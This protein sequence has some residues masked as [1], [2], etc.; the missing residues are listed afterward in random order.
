MLLIYKWSHVHVLFFDAVLRIVLVF[1][2]VQ[3]YNLRSKNLFFKNCWQ[4]PTKVS[5][6]Y[7]QW[8]PT[9]DMFLKVPITDIL[10]FFRNIFQEQLSWHKHPHLIIHIIFTVFLTIVYEK[11][12]ERYIKWQR[13]TTSDSEWYNQWQRMTTSDNGMTTSGT[14]S[15]NESYNEWQRMITSD[16]EWLLRPIFFSLFFS[17]GTN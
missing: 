16:N 4:N 10:V 6:M 8:T 15:D 11:T 17:R 12:D 7:H 14:K 9:V 1:G 2:E 13:M 5:F 3:A